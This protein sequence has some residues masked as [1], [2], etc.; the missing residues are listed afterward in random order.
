MFKDEKFYDLESPDEAIILHKEMWGDMLKDLG[1]NPTRGERDGYKI[2]WLMRKGYTEVCCDCFL[3][4]FA[5]QTRLRDSCKHDRCH[6]CPINWSSLS[7]SCNP[8]GC[9]D[10]YKYGDDYIYR[11][12]P[13][14]E[15]L[16]LPTKGE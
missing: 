3:C 12:A 5:L 16:A 15:I 10:I 14:S 6:Y 9:F 8:E 4:E 2:I 1:D 7:N 13:I 11:C